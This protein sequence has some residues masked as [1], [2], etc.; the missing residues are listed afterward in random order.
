MELARHWL[1]NVTSSI[2]S[3]NTVKTVWLPDDYLLS[4]KSSWVI[5]QIVETFYALPHFLDSMYEKL[6][7]PTSSLHLDW[8][9]GDDVSMTIS[10][11]RKST[12]ESVLLW[13]GPTQRCWW[14][15]EDVGSLGPPGPGLLMEKTF[16]SL[17]PLLQSTLLFLGK[18]TKVTQPSHS[19][20]F[21]RGRR[22]R[23][24]ALSVWAA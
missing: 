5:K 15:I 21:G 22:Q 8:E 10:V 11:H 20:W 19:V 23:H 18:K 9:T 7:K 2:V 14:C 6:R 13:N 4:F 12:Q 17:K 24:C 1:G 3:C 16:F